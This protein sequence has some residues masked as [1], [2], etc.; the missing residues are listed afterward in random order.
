MFVGFTVP[1]FGGGARSK[2]LSSPRFYFFYPGIRTA[3]AGQKFLA[4][5]KPQYGQLPVHI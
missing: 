3:A 1:A 4:R 2:L 5:Q